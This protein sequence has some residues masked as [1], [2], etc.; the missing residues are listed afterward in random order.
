MAA[1]N[2]TVRV[3]DTQLTAILTRMRDIPC[4]VFT[5]GKD[6]VLTGVARG[7]GWNPGFH[8]TTTGEPMH[9]DLPFVLKLLRDCFLPLSCMQQS[10][11]LRP[12]V[13]AL[14]TTPAQYLQAYHT[15]FPSEPLQG[16]GEGE[17]E[18]NFWPLIHALARHG[19][20]VVVDGGQAVNH[21]A[22]AQ[23]EPFD[24]VNALSLS[25]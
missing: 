12:E 7:R 4:L 23:S 17:K 19:L 24:V 25:D 8:Q 16:E 13:V 11:Q 21:S 15:T 3:R 9:G 22:L 10:G 6:E 2:V 14:L 1:Q 18:G 5:A 20:Y